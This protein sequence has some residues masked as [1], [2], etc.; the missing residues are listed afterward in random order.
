MYQKPRA[1]KRLYFDVIPR[2]VD[3]YLAFASKFEGENPAQRLENP[4]WHIHDGQPPKLS[5]DLSYGILLNLASVANAEEPAQLWGF[6]TRYRPDATPQSAP[7]LDKLVGYAIN[8]Y[9]DFVKPAKKYRTPNE[10]ER[11]A[12]G[13]LLAYIERA[14]ADADAETLQT[15]VY[16]IG[17]RHPFPELRAWFKALY[18]VLLGQDQGPRFG[19]FIALYGRKETAELIRKALASPSGLAAE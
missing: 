11:K 1:A 3:D 13:E 2:A 18:E 12:L 17:K 15:E 7:F 6:I 9:R 14:P 10:I 5:S 19:S 8:Y 16:E 4:V